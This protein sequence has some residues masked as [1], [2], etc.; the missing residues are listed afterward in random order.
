[1]STIRK[2]ISKE[3]LNELPLL[4][5]D[6][7]IHLIE[8]SQRPTTLKTRF[9]VETQK[10]LRTSRLTDEPI[11]MCY[12]EE[13]V[14]KVIEVIDQVDGIIVSVFGLHAC[15]KPSKTAIPIIVILFI[16]FS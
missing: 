4:K 16:A 15:T 9:L 5:L 13:L 11:P 1:M 3:E 7:K 2:E 10:M 8:D 12:I 6:A 14:S